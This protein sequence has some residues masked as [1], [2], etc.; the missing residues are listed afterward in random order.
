MDPGFALMEALPFHISAA[1]TNVTC[2]LHPV[3]NLG[4]S[5]YLKVLARLGLPLLISCGARNE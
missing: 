5:T 4:G 3:V 1:F 2:V